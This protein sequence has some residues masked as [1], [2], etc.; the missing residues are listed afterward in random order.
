[1][2]RGEIE[3]L[4]RDFNQTFAGEDVITADALFMWATNT[5]AFHEWF[6]TRFER[7]ASQAVKENRFHK[8]F[9]TYRPM[10]LEWCAWE[11]I[12]CI[13]SDFLRGCVGN[14]Q[15]NVYDAES[16]AGRQVYE[17]YI[18]LFQETLAAQDKP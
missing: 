10:F 3:S 11:I 18:R 16:R 1:M 6:Y 4:Q 15:T 17:Y 13:Y 7:M 9:R 12:P 8:Y 2:C 14:R 5:S